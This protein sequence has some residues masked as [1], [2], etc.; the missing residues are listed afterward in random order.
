MREIT[1]HQG[2]GRLNHIAQTSQRRA[3]P[4]ATP[5]GSF[6]FQIREN[7]GLNA[8]LRD[9]VEWEKDGLVSIPR[10]GRSGGR[11]G[12]FLGPDTPDCRLRTDPLR[13]RT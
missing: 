8:I 13:G 5:R 2:F 10:Q 12:R 1:I 11:Q 9:D 6:Q 4:K 7:F 3:R